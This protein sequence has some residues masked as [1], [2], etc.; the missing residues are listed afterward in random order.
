MAVP[1]VARAWAIV[2]AGAV[3]SAAQTGNLVGNGGVERASPERPDCPTDF[4]PGRVGAHP[5]LTT[6]EAPGYD[7]PHCLAVQTSDSSGLGYWQTVVPVSPATTYTLSFRYRTARG[8]PPRGSGDPLYNQGR[9]GG[10]NVELGMVPEGPSQGAKPSAWSD[11]GIALP[12]VG[13]LFLPVADEWS[14]HRQVLTT[15]PDQTRL[16]IKLRLWCY[17]QKA[18]FDDLSLTEGTTEDPQPEPEPL[19][20]L[21]D[22]TPPTVSVPFP[23]PGSAVEPAAAIRVQFADVGAGVEP[24]S[25]HLEV[26]GQDVTA[27][28]SL[29]ATGIELAAATPWAPGTHEV[30]VQLRDRAGNPGNALRWRFGVGTAPRRALTVEQGHMR[31]D[32][33]PFFPIGIYAY[34]C[35]PD[36]G[37]FREDHLAQAAA[38]GFNLVLNTIEKRAGLDRELAAGIMGTL[39]ITA[40]LRACT[41]AAAAAESLFGKGQARLADH[42]AVMAYWADD[43]ENLEDTRETPM[44]ET[45]IAA[46]R[47]ATTALRQ[48]TPGIP[49]IFAISNLPRLQ[50]AMQFG[51]ILL[52]YRYAVPHYHPAM[53]HGYT[54]AVCQTMVPDRP[55]W[56]LSQAIHLGYGASLGVPEFRP[57]PA[58]MEAMA[59]Y[60]LVCGVAGYCLYANYV[61]AADH[62]EH[63]GM[64]L[65]LACRLRHLGPA[66]AAGQAARTVEAGGSPQAGSVFWRETEH[67]GEHTLL[68]VNLSGGTVPLV[69]TFARPV[70]AAVLFED[71]AMAR[72]S[73]SVSEVFAPWQVHIYQWR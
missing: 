14:L 29:G 49:T 62:P 68:A 17:A 19:W 40:E 54:I 36:D 63:W 15:R 67:A 23:P 43:P 24:G 56:F 12:P 35:H 6:W 71:R 31:L 16:A 44:S 33:E 42:P 37:R 32:G 53:I 28:A 41:D 55:L 64:A 9:P 2:L 58:E 1:W 10:P 26:D 70:R 73:A 60:S 3:L 65:S 59:F 66:L 72:E 57:T 30:R 51:D 18:W 8:A 4:V 21:A 61:N 13:G 48:R 11:I 52:S 45:A 46:L 20:A 39:N 34:A 69:W 7:S 38:A 5:A 25:V 22:T 27:K 50:P 47:Q